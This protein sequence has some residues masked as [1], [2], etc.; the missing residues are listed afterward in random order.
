LTNV[1]RI[2]N[3]PIPKSC[4]FF[5][6]DIPIRYL[7]QAGLILDGIHLKQCV[8]LYLFSLPFT[9]VSD[10]GWATVP[11][12]TVVSFTFMGIE[13]IAE[14]IEMPFG[15]HVCFR[16]VANTLT[17]SVQALMNL[18]SRW[19]GLYIKLGNSLLIQCMLHR[20]LLLGFEGRD[21]VSNTFFFSPSSS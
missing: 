7:T 17:G 10:L 13:G 19:V 4:T 21:Q 18:I 8:T 3:T 16:Y 15:E 14:Q 12:V 5:F 9:M 6:R 20:S 11:I 2:A 1:E